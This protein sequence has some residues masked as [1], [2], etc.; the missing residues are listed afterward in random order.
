MAERKPQRLFLAYLSAQVASLIRRVYVSPF[1]ATLF[2]ANQSLQKGKE[3]RPIIS[4]ETIS[5]AG[6]A[7]RHPFT[8]L[9]PDLLQDPGGPLGRVL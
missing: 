7:I 2:N 4:L 8:P 5:R 9:L 1:L 3:N 6:G